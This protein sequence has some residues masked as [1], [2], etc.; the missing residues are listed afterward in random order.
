MSQISAM[1]NWRDLGACS[2]CGGLCLQYKTA[3]GTLH[4]NKCCIEWREVSW[5]LACRICKKRK[6]LRKDENSNRDR[7][8]I[9]A[10]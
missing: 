5:Y 8:G 1:Y 4:S 7:P 3:G 2:K 9:R 6:E 10:H